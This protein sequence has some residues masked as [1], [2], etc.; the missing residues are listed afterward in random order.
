MTQENNWA[1]I[2]G[3]SSGV[4][5]ACSL[6]LARAGYSIFGVHLDRQNTMPNVQRIKSEI[7]GMGQQAIF[8][9]VNA[10]DAEKRASVLQSIKTTFADNKVGQVQVLLHSIA[11]GTLKQ[12]IADDAKDA[13]SQ[14]QIDMT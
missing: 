3:A 8:F 6:E 13:I 12:Y 14:K 5:E 11:F 9:N 4:G 1:L 10:A 2:L 7:E